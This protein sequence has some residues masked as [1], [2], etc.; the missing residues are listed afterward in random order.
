MAWQEHRSTHKPE[1]K[2]D[3]GQTKGRRA[4]AQ[5]RPSLKNEMRCKEWRPSDS[6]T[7]QEVKNEQQNMQQRPDKPPGYGK[8]MNNK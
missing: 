8:R 5:A 1:V 3:R 4:H 2:K 7:P 6:S